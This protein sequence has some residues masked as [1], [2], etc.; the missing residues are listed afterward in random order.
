MCYGPFCRKHHSL[1]TFLGEHEI[2]AIKLSGSGDAVVTNIGRD[3]FNYMFKANPVVQ[4]TRNGKVHSVYKRISEVPDGF[5]AYSIFTYTWS[6]T[7]NE[8]NVDFEIYCNIHASE[9]EENKW[10]YCNYNELNVGYPRDCGK[11]GAVFNTWFSLPNGT[12]SAPGLTNGSSFQLFGGLNHC[13]M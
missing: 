12:Y 1:Q 4:Y 11:S 9:V 13:F 3:N 6:S 5:D 10:A 7:Y 8:L 2:T